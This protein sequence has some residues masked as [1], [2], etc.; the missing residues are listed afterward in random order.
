MIESNKDVFK[1]KIVAFK[2]AFGELFEAW[3]NLN[4][5][6]SK[7]A[8]IRYPFSTNFHNL[9][10]EVIDWV[11]TYMAEKKKYIIGVYEIWE[12]MHEVEAASYEEA[13]DIISEQCEGDKILNDQFSF[14]DFD[15]KPYHLYE[16]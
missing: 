3:T 4:S 2:M 6:D 5:E 12:Q 8:D 13:C 16:K 7:K 1:E 14:V 15:N 11:D 9:Y 10:Y